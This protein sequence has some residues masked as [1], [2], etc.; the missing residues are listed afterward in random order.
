MEGAVAA[1]QD[2]LRTMES[3]VLAARAEQETTKRELEITKRELQRE[4]QTTKRELQT[5]EHTTKRN[6][7]IAK[8]ELQTTKMELQTTKR[9]LQASR[10]ERQTGQDSVS[11]YAELHRY[12]GVVHVNC[13]DL[14]NERMIESVVVWWAG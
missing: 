8:K 4:Q 7:Q 10:K 3:L 9:E 5:E 1:L 6:V 14:I 11:K 2:K 13:A 12:Q